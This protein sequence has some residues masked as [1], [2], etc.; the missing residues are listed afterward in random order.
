MTRYP[1][2]LDAF[3]TL[4]DGLDTLRAAP[5]NLLLSALEA[6][7]SEL[8]TNPSGTFATLAARLDDLKVVERGEGN[9]VDAD[10]QSTTGVTV[11]LSEPFSDTAKMVV[12]VAP[13]YDPVAAGGGNNAFLFYVDNITTT[14]FRLRAW[15]RDGSNPAGTDAHDIRWIAFQFP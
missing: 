13:H 12:I 4:T 5:W 8:G 11:G 3:P 2:A 7:E 10:L 14:N 15:A 6:I 9:F 1:A